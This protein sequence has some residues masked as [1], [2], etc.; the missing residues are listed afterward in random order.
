VNVLDELSERAVAT[1]IA[2]PPSL[3]RVRT[4]AARRRRHR[5]AGRA[6]AG[7]TLAAV[8][9]A[10]VVVTT[11]GSGRRVGV[12]GTPRPV[13][14][15]AGVVTHP[16]LQ[17]CIPATAREG[18]LVGS[19]ITSPARP[20]E[21]FWD[22]TRGVGGPLAVLVRE[23]APA[24]G[25][26]GKLPGLI[27]NLTIA[28]RP[29]NYGAAQPNSGI[30][31]LL[32]NGAFASLRAN[33]M[34]ESELVALATEISVPT[35]HPPAGLV[36]LGTTSGAA[37]WAWSSCASPPDHFGAWVVAV[38][39]PK[40]DRY[41]Y[42]VS[43]APGLRW[44]VGDLTYVLVAEPGETPSTPPAI[45]Q[46]SDDEWRTLLAATPQPSTPVPPSTAPR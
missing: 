1:P 21:V 6:L 30:D 24:G 7:V 37:A 15:P 5:I 19:G 16:L 2:P 26:D 45:R 13:Q 22:P 10:G 18:T 43:Q 3:D 14:V 35:G 44:D 46:A 39:G 23:Q 27:P 42:A 41:A 20:G 36:S 33:D 34:S 11:D 25:G 29:G 12:A 9:A 17:S 31:W 40:A 8:A 32:P 38:Q 4:R 28:G